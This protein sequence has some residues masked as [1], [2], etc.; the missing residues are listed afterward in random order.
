M[1][2]ARAVVLAVGLGGLGLL[3]TLLWRGSRISP[4]KQSPTQIEL[5]PGM[6][7]DVSD[8]LRKRQAVP[9]ISASKQVEEAVRSIVRNGRSDAPIPKAP[10]TELAKL[11]L[12]ADAEECSGWVTD[13]NGDGAPDVIIKRYWTGSGACFDLLV[14][15]TF[16]A[17][18]KWCSF[19]GSERGVTFFGEGHIPVEAHLLDRGEKG[20]RAILIP[21][22]IAN[23][24]ADSVLNWPTV[25]SLREGKFQVADAEH[26][27]FYEDHLLPQF[28]RAGV[29]AD[30]PD[31]KV[32][33]ELV[34][35][36]GRP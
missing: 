1:T 20:N 32:V 34:R 26:R 19:S 33:R 9:L 36:L 31:A 16:K 13:V 30:N 24:G 27:G 22:C 29:S 3:G 6:P 11:I 18:I 5:M 15:F 7:L 17:G 28:G 21:D 2:K 8:Y 10:A 4:A 35:G 12:E 14:C 25:Y 23:R